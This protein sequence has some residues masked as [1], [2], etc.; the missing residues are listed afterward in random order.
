M[1]LSRS[2]GLSLV[3]IGGG[4]A[5][6]AMLWIWTFAPAPFARVVLTPSEQKWLAAHGPLHFAPD[7]NFSPLEFFDASGVYRGV[8]ADYFRLIEQRLG[9]PIKIFRYGT[10]DEVLVAART[11][12]IDGI[13][14]AQITPE[15]SRYLAYT[16]P[17]LDIP[18]VIIVRTENPRALSFHDLEGK[19]VVVTRGNALDEHIRRTFPGILLR[20]EPDDLACLREVSFGR[21]E[22]SVVNL[23]IASEL[24]DQ[25]GITNLRVAG[26]SGRSNALAIAVRKELPLLRAIME[27]GLASVSDREGLAIRRRWIRL[28]GASYGPGRVLTRLFLVVAA[29]MTVATIFFLLWNAVLRRKVQAAT[30]D[31]RIELSERH[32]AE[33][34]LGASQR[35]VAAHLEQTLFFVIEWDTNGCVRDWNPAAEQVFGY[36]RREALGRTGFELL[37][38]D[39]SR[40]QLEK[41]WSDLI[42]GRGGRFDLS[43]NRTKDDRRIFCEWFNT[44]LVDEDGRAIG[45]MSIGQDVT[46]RVH[47]AE[48]LAQSQRLESLAVLAGGIAHDFNNL[49]A[50]ILGNVALATGDRR[51]PDDLRE[52]LADAEAAAQRARGLTQQ[53]LT[54]SRGGAPVKRVVDLEPVVREAAHFAASG[55]NC[56]CTVDAEAAL[57]PADADAHQ[58]AQIVQN[59]VLNAGEAMPNGGKIEVELANLRCNPADGTAVGARP[60]LRLGVSDRG[61]GIDPAQSPRIFDPFFSTKEQGSGLGLAVCHSIAV[62]HGGSIRALPRPGGGTVFELLLPAKPGGLIEGSAEHDSM[63]SQRVRVLVLD[64]EATLRRLAVRIF[65]HLGCEAETCGDGDETVRLYEEARRLGRPYDL[66]VLDLTIP[67]GTGGLDTLE[68]LQAIDPSVRAIVSSGYSTDPVMASYR[69]HGFAAVLPKPFTPADVGR[70]IETALR[71][72]SPAVDSR[73]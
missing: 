61:P 23:A 27:K 18:N 17:I 13:T 55:S 6:L 52:I 66:V 25:Q 45:A 70:A 65:A 5:V 38:P 73:S 47:S 44:L 42:G 2:Q 19:Q 59:L 51:L 28:D 54:F 31:L 10:W 1:R 33:L 43:R 21:A 16:A 22:A 7:P 20:T 69:E 62:R 3:F 4:V 50:G 67:G 26:D 35:R 14:A 72:R 60:C 34:A 36:T 49:L 56:S 46:D 9:T 58:I 11:G 68:R 29:A 39:E 32:R 63:P 12:E 30:S 24:I 71:D 37:I 48:A 40:A 57:W 41:V 15:R 64:D 53:L 8:V